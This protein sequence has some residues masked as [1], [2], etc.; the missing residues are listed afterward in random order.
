MKPSLA[1]PARPQDRIALGDMKVSFANVL[2]CEYD[3][4]A[5][6][7]NYSTFI[8]ES[9]C[10]TKRAKTCNPVSRRTVDVDLN[11]QPAKLGD[12][13]IVIAAITS[14]TNTSNP[15]VML[16][17]GLLAKA[18]AEKGL[19]VPPHV[20]TSLAPGSKVVVDYLE[21]AGLMPYL[22][23]MGFHVAGFGCTTCIGNSGPLHPGIE[24]AIK[25]NDLTVASVLS[26]NRNFEA[27]IHQSIKG[28]YLASPMLVVAFAIAGRIDVDLEHEPV[29]LDPN[30]DPVYL[31]QIWPSEETIAEL[32]QKHVKEEFFRREY[33]RIYDG[34]EFWRE[35]DVA[36]KHH[37]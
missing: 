16:G 9:G 33:G 14:C 28:N 3:R 26:G 12:G 19:K 17:A 37:F 32:V 24:K 4:D 30:G 8:D 35:L 31:D 23:T 36:E 7:K 27:R 15:S 20:K 29:G 25:D 10:E 1:G 11:G 6:A 34:D 2:G 13:C 22:Q 18:A 5:E 21:D